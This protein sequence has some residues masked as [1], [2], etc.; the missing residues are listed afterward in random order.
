[1][2]EHIRNLDTRDDALGVVGGKG[3]SLAKMTNAGF[4][5]PHGFLVTTSAYQH[6]VASHGL[7]EE[8]IAKAKPEVASG[9][10][11]FEAASSGVRTLFSDHELADDIA[12]EIADAYD[13]L[14]GAPA[15]AVR[16]SATAED[17]PGLSFAG[18]QE[19]FLNVRGAGEVVAAV[20]NCWASLWTAQAISYRHQNAIDQDAVA[21]AVVV[22]VMVPSEVSGI[23]FTANPATGERGEMIIN[24]SFGLGEAVVSGQVTPDTYILDKAT[25]AATETII[26][27]KDQ[28]II[29]DGEQGTRLADVAEADRQQ[30]SLTD[31]RLKEL[32]EAALALEALYE[33]LP[34]DIEWAFS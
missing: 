27:P 2:S 9:R 34:Q 28:Q 5:V 4:N 22:Q 25:L 23:L 18:Q 31:D 7:Q 11:S 26:G 21:M 3:R 15:V 6:F 12:R 8:I 13:A 24:A 10:V 30:S 17:L 29:S 1:M 14:P 19:T 20:K 32:G 33:G 16:S